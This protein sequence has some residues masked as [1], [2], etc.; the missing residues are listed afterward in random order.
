MA[1]HDDYD[2]CASHEGAS[3]RNGV[4]FDEIHSDK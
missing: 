2:Y 4:T 1:K 3:I